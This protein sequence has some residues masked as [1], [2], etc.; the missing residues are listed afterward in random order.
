ML[1]TASDYYCWLLPLA[2]AS[3]HCLCL[4]PLS[5]AFVY[6]FVYCFCLLPLHVAIL[7]NCQTAYLVPV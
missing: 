5:T 6:S 1:S 3:V 4:L 2:V 7:L